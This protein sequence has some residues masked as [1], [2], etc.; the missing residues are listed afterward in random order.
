VAPATTSETFDYTPSTVLPAGTIIYFRLNWRD[1]TA[2]DGNISMACTNL[3]SSETLTLVFNNRSTRGTEARIYG[4]TTRMGTAQKTYSL[5][6][7]NTAA[8]GNT[9]KVHLY[10]FYAWGYFNHP[11]PTSTISNPAMADS[12][13][14]VG[15]WTH[16]T[17]WTNYLGTPYSLSTSYTADTR[18]LF[19]S[20]G[21]R[22]DGALKP[23][24][25]A[26]GAAT[27]S[28]RESATGLAASSSNIID[29]DGYNLDG[30][31]PANYY[32]MSGTSMAC[33][34]AAGLAALVL[35]AHP[36]LTPTQLKQALISTASQADGPDNSAGYGLLDALTPYRWISNRRQ[37]RWTQTQPNRP[38][39]PSFPSSS[40]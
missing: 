3:G 12:A 34:H 32:V 36:S 2:Y 15:A 19:S 7:Q 17:A 30:S 1:E 4:L 39:R 29:N 14:A 20:Q 26:P 28:A 18:A 31:G 22:I 35:E 6:L 23:E 37:S 9:P 40:L 10:E 24:I 27:I 5:T 33:P 21:P 38:A 25:V 16:R 13:I 11:D 8:S